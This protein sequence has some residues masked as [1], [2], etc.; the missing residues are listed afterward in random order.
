MLSLPSVAAAYAGNSA[1]DQC[2]LQSLRD[3]WNSAA[4][5]LIQQS[6][7]TLY[8]NGALLLPRERAF[9]ECMIQALPGV[10]DDFAIQQISAICRR[11]GAM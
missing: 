7:D 5:M 3:S 4:S 9:H 1:Y 10:R 8:R 6:C 11:R 2:V